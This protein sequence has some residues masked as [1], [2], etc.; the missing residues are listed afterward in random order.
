[1]RLQ[2]LAVLALGSLSNL[3]AQ[4]LSTTAD[5][6]VVLKKQRV[7]ELFSHGTLIKT[8]KVALSAQPRS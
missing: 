1:M 4:S 2:V 5:R 8:Y 3:T 6:V 7:L